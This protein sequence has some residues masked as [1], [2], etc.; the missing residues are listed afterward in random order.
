MDGAPVVSGVTSDSN[1]MRVN[2]S[3]LP[4]SMEAMSALFTA[5]QART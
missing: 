5:S 4:R 3:R 1:Q 2:I